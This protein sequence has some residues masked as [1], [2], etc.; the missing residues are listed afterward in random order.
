MVNVISNSFEWAHSLPVSLKFILSAIIV[1][2][3]LLLLALLWYP[4]A[5]S[6][7][8]VNSKKFQ[9]L[10][11]SEINEI[12]DRTS[13]SDRRKMNSIILSLYLTYHRGEVLD[14]LEE[15]PAWKDHLKKLQT[16][17]DLEMPPSNVNLSE[18]K[19]YYRSLVSRQHWTSNRALEEI[20][21][22]LPNGMTIVVREMLLLYNLERHSTFG[23]LLQLDLSGCI[24]IHAD[25]VALRAWGTIIQKQRAS[26]MSSLVSGLVDIARTHIGNEQ[27][28]EVWFQEVAGMTYRRYQERYDTEMERMKRD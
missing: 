25:E 12:A 27:N 11:I 5:N 8:D 4:S 23:W 16:A 20:S 3:F 14:R 26:P 10:P 17:S 18:I 28:F 2:C 13:D 7:L 22:M 19:G 15:Y 1:L 21:E 6:T 9:P 24:Q